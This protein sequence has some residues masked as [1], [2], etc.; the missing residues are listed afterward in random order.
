MIV[1]QI[2]FASVIEYNFKIYN[3]N[4][5]TQIVKFFGGKESAERDLK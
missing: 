2:I 4:L 5:T 3:K 1:Q